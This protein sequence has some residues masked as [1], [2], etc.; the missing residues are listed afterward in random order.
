VD[1]PAVVAHEQQVADPDV[2]EVHT[3]RVDPEMV[4]QLGVAGGD[5]SEYALAEAVRWLSMF[6]DTAALST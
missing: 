5:V 4:G 1:D 2:P 6:L 3:E